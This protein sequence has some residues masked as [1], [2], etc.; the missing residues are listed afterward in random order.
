M[1]PFPV[2][3]KR[4]KPKSHRA[5]VVQLCAQAICLEEML[6]VTIPVGALFYGEPRRR[7]DVAFDAEL[8]SLTEEVARGVHELIDSGETPPPSFGKWCASCS[9]VDECRPKLVASH[10]SA[11]AWLERAMEEATA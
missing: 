11:K 1:Q 9:L 5:D 3:Y 8:R 2:E 7:T 6:G 4:G 10:R